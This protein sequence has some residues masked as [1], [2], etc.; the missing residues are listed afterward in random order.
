MKE[1]R[2]SYQRD[3]CFDSSEWNPGG[4]F[5]ERVESEE[6]IRYSVFQPGASIPLHC[7]A[8]SKILMAYLPGERMGWDHLC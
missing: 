3:R 6:P 2:P 8:S 1:A 4:L 7:G 5:L